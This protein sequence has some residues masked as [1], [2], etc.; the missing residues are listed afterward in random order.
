VNTDGGDS[1]GAWF[2][3]IVDIDVTAEKAQDSLLPE[4]GGKR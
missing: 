4:R 3:T 2:Q 1:M